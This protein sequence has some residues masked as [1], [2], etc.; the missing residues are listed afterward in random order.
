MRTVRFLY[1]LYTETRYVHAL[2]GNCLVK[3][4]AKPC[5][6]TQTNSPRI[7]H[8]HRKI[9]RDSPGMPGPVAAYGSLSC[10]QKFKHTQ[11]YGNTL[12]IAF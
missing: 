9:A 7:A 6:Q 11:L 1:K 2:A 3:Q 10:L 5:R 12:L 4:P 8:A